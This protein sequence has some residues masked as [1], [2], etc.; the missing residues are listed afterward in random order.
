MSLTLCLNTNAKPNIDRQT[1][2]DNESFFE[3]VRDLLTSC[4]IF[5]RKHFPPNSAPHFKQLRMHHV[6]LPP[7]GCSCPPSGFTHRHKEKRGNTAI[8]FVSGDEFPSVSLETSSRRWQTNTFFTL[9][10]PQSLSC[11]FFPLLPFP[12]FL[13]PIDFPISS[14]S[15]LSSARTEEAEEAS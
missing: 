9:S 1:W 2:P 12:L 3:L 13:K 14:P 11:F 4:G 15:H 10:P 8:E 6:Y 5:T 7:L